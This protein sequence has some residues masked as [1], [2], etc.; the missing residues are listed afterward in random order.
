MQFPISFLQAGITGFIWSTIGS[1][2]AA[3]VSRREQGV[4]TGVNSAIGGLMAAAGPLLAGVAYDKIGM[5]SPFTYGAIIPVLAMVLIV[6]MVKASASQST[7][8][9]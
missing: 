5:A 4:L 3:Q 1:L 6:V 8:S 9:H 2:S 7:T